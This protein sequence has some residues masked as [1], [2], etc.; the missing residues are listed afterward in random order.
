MLLALTQP[1]GLPAERSPSPLSVSHGAGAASMFPDFMD[2]AAGAAAPAAA[3]MA[4]PFSISLRQNVTH[5]KNLVWDFRNNLCAYTLTTRTEVEQNRPEVDHVLEIQQYELALQSA[6][7]NAPVAARTRAVFQDLHDNLRQVANLVR[8]LN[9][10]T[11]R[12]NQAKKGPV[13]IFLRQFTPAAAGTGPV[14]SLTSLVRGHRNN[15]IRDM[16]DKGHWA[17]L[18]CTMVETWEDAQRRLDEQL[19]NQ[20]ARLA[21]DAFVD[22]MTGMMSR[23]EVF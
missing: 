4:A 17:R 9:V 7:M 5:K 16:V 12:V 13:S 15:T 10:T 1:H 21:L 20:A 11:N 23:L 19:T 2:A 3:G 14:Q 8:S 18:E 6:L 22:E